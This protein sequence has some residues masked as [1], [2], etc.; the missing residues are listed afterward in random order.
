MKQRLRVAIAVTSLLVAGAG[1]LYCQTAYAQGR[2]DKWIEAGHRSG[3]GVRLIRLSYSPP[4]CAFV[5][6]HNS[7]RSELDKLEDDLEKHYPVALVEAARVEHVYL[8]RAQLAQIVMYLACLSKS[9]RGAF[10][11]EQAMALF[12]S[13]RYGREAFRVLERE[14]ATRGGDAKDAK[15]F[16]W[17]MRQYMKPPTE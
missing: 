4:S 14:S 15:F 17:Q 1:S 12:A 5:K 8:V 3:H 10:V 11:P 16:L 6:S 9:S 13:K 2:D 7:P